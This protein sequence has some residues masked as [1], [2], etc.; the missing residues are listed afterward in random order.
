MSAALLKFPPPEGEFAAAFPAGWRCVAGTPQARALRY[1][2]APD[3]SV[4]AGHWSCTEGVFE[5]AYD[6]WEFCHLISGRCRITPSGAPPVELGP[7]DGFILESG[8]VGHWEVL[9]PMTKHFVFKLDPRAGQ[10]G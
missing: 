1:Y 2:T 8:F 5:V 7:G 10:A 3:G 4:L 6:K 9:E